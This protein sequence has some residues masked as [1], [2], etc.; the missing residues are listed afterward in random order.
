M[1]LTFGICWI[2][3]QASDAEVEAVEA[4]VRQCGFEPEI[5]RI[6]TEAQITEFAALQKHYHD[7]D[8][9]LLDL[10][11]GNGM[12]GN[13]LAP[14]IRGHFRSTPIL[15]YSGEDEDKLRKLMCDLLVEGVYCI[16]RD[17]LAARVT[18]LVEALTPALNSLSS[19][20]GLAAR[21]VAECDQ[22]FRSILA[23]LAKPE[24]KDGAIFE[25][26]KNRVCDGAEKTITAT[27]EIKSLSDLLDGTVSSHVLFAE[28]RDRIR[29]AD[30]SDEVRDM[31][32][33]LKEYPQ[34]LLYRRNALSHALE[35]RTP[36]GWKI[37]RRNMKPLTV[38]DFERYRR[39]F[40][41]I[42]QNLRKLRMHLIPEQAKEH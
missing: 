34:R 27:K 39:D 23:Y 11:L 40:L 26:M 19:M 30:G 38:A 42:L 28:S 21:V 31:L 33:S 3:D 41:D 6:E 15:F 12:K 37:H 22:E 25:S 35:E 10:R 17:R 1:S 20:R 5:H 13:D 14:Q 18:E 9:I 8:L 29:E 2:E 24:G 16:H 7:Y 4:A 36:E 32:R